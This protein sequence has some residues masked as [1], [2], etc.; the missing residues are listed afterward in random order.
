MKARRQAYEERL[1]LKAKAEKRKKDE[2]QARI[3]DIERQNAVERLAF[4]REEAMKKREEEEKKQQD[5][6]RQAEEATRRK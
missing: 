6:R 4:K 2:E 1:A 3:D 5:R